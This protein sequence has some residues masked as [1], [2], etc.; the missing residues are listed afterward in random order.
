M[1]ILRKLSKIFKI[2]SS[3]SVPVTF[4]QISEISFP[5]YSVPPNNLVYRSD[6]FQSSSN[7]QVSLPK[8][9]E[10]FE[11]SKSIAFN[12]MLFLANEINFLFQNIPLSKLEGNEIA[13]SALKEIFSE[14]KAQNFI[15]K[16][17]PN[18]IAKVRSSGFHGLKLKKLF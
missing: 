3:T 13:I 17:K 12:K 18:K 5:Y 9:S 6:S 11:N 1:K 14:L 8:K 16:S 4:D 7:S 15:F 10:N 2:S